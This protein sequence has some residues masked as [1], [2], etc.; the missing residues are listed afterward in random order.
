MGLFSGCYTRP[1]QVLTSCDV[2]LN[3]QNG[4]NSKSE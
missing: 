2:I 4:G 1:Y 3:K